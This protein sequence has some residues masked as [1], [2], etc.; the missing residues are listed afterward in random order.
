MPL[1]GEPVPHRHP[2]VLAHGLDGF[3]GEAAVF[4]PVEHAPEDA[5][6]VFHRLFG[7]QM[8]FPGPEAGDVRSLVVR[9]DLEGRT[10]PGGS[11]LEDQGDV[12]PGQ[13]VSLE[14]KSL[15]LPQAAAEVDQ[16]DEL[17]TGQ[18]SFLQQAPASQI[19]D[20]LLPAAGP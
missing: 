15:L 2:G 8:G 12:P 18:V 6:G 19:H 10:G 13:P 9:G 1:V 20:G 4:D 14:P 5:G 3:L 11:L 17:L 16:V 7:A